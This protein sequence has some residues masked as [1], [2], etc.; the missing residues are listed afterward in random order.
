[1]RRNFFLKKLFD[2][3]NLPSFQN[4]M[5]ATKYIIDKNPKQNALRKAEET[6][7]ATCLEI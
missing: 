7:K 1:M 2:D 3:V 6:S 5:R 4:I